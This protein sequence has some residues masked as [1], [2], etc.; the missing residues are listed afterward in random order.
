V[1]VVSHEDE[2]PAEEEGFPF[3]ALVIMMVIIAASGAGVVFVAKRDQGD[4]RV[5]TGTAPISEALRAKVAELEARVK[6][7]EVDVNAPEF[8]VDTASAA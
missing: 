4:T 3:L 5:D 1:V 2:T 7:E 8:E 6:V